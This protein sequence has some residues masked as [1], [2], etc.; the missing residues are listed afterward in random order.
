MNPL[1]SGFAS[2][3]IIEMLPLAPNQPQ[4]SSRQQHSREYFPSS[5]SSHH[6]AI[7]PCLSISILENAS[8]PSFPLHTHFGMLPFVFLL[9]SLGHGSSSRHQHSRQCFPSSFSS[10][11]W[12]R[13]IDPCIGISILENASLCLSPPVAGI[14]ILVSALACSAFSELRECFPSPFSSVAGIPILVSALAFSRMLP[15]LHFGF[16]PHTH[17]GSLSISTLMDASLHPNYYD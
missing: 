1:R 3:A 14:L 16:P 6:S 10:H 11:H 7:D 13:A 2:D 15:S 17:S 4:S 12:A 9:P 5:F 8:L